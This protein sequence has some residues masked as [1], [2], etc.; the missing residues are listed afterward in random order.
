MVYLAAIT[1][2]APAAGEY[3]VVTGP[4]GPQGEQGLQGQQGTQG[5]QGERGPAGA[6]GWGT[7][8]SYDALAARVSAVESG[9]TSVNAYITDALNRIASLESRV[10]ALENP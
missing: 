4:R 8:A 1:P 2:T 3:T 6:D 10:T 7:Q 9:F 5:P